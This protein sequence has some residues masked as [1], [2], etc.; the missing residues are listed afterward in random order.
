MENEAFPTEALWSVSMDGS[1]FFVPAGSVLGLSDPDGEPVVTLTSRRPPAT[2]VTVAERDLLSLAIDSSKGARVSREFD[3]ERVAVEARDVGARQVPVPSD[4]A[5]DVVVESG[6]S[7]PVSEAARS[8]R[9]A[10]AALLDSRPTKNMSFKFSE[11]LADEAK[12]RADADR[13]TM[14]VLCRSAVF[15]YLYGPEPSEAVEPDD[16]SADDLMA[17]LREVKQQLRLLTDSSNNTSRS[18]EELPGRLAAG[19]QQAG[20]ALAQTIRG[21]LGEGTTEVIDVP[22]AAINWPEL[23]LGRRLRYALFGMPGQTVRVTRS[24][25]PVVEE[26][27]EIE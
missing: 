23:P 20:A 25:P 15:L 5:E 1:T 10:R 9:E 2:E 8:W 4:S 19:M 7:V 11:A 27:P 16:E 12:E 21:S 26:E 18:V 13:T 6:E 14:A 17:E 22:A 24:L 3:A